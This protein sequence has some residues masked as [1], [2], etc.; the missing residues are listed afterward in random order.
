MIVNFYDQNRTRVIPIRT[1][2]IKNQDST[3][4]IIGQI[5][6]DK[7]GSKYKYDIVNSKGT[8][9]CIE[10]SDRTTKIEEYYGDGSSPD[11]QSKMEHAQY[12]SYWDKFE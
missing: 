1:I 4:I 8:K 11:R 7:L 2:V 9:V 12:F 3:Y 6:D 10:Q 5:P